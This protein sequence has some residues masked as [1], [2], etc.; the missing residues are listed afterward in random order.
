MTKIALISLLLLSSI[1]NSCFNKEAEKNTVTQKNQT[2]K[3]KNPIPVSLNVMDESSEILYAY[4]LKKD[5]NAAEK[6]YQKVQEEFYTLSPYLKKDSIPND[7]L[8]SLETAVKFLARDIEDKNQVAALSDANNI[9]AYMCDVAD[10]FVTDY[11]SNLRRVH[12]HTRNIEISILQD[13]W[14]DARENFKK[15]NAYWPKVKGVL[16]QKS[17][18][19]VKEFEDSF[20]DFEYLLNKKDESKT[21]KQTQIMRDKT[22]SLEKYYEK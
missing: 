12:V 6:Q 8:V 11:P 17:E 10:Y 21:L 2:A 20:V 13:K 18:Q 19:K 14:E 5:W 3:Q 16:S 7:Y 9:T 22:E 1:F 15:V 4:L